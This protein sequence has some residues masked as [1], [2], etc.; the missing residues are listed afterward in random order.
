MFTLPNE[1]QVWHRDAV[2]HR[3]DAGGV[4]QADDIKE[5][6]DESVHGKLIPF[7]SSCMSGSIELSF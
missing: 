1:I 3:M 4:S 6:G 5:S 2:I 7:V